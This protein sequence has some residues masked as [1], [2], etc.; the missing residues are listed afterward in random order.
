MYLAKSN[1]LTKEMKVSEEK[2]ILM[3]DNNYSKSRMQLLFN[4]FVKQSKSKKAK[5]Y[6]KPY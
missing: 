6:N 3:L 1:N 5:K 2:H 4:I